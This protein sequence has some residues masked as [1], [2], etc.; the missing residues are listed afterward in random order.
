[1]L[2]CIVGKVVL[3]AQ[4]AP[5]HASGADPTSGLTYMSIAGLYQSRELFKYSTVSTEWSM[6]DAGAGVTGKGPGERSGHTM[7]AVGQDLYVFGG[8]VLG[9]SR[10]G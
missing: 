10:G 3:S 2:E 7:A 4:A 9:E 1:M 8:F 5:Q 6:L